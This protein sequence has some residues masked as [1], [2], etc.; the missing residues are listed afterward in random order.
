MD[1][2]VISE[3]GGL[4]VYVILFTT[5]IFNREVSTDHVLT[6]F[7]IR[8]RWL[9]SLTLFLFKTRNK[10]FAWRPLAYIPCE[11]YYS[12]KQYRDFPT[13]TKIFR[14]FQLY[15]AGLASFIKA[16]QPGAMNDVYLPLGDKGKVV[17]MLIPLAFIIG[18]NQGGDGIAGRAAYYGLSA[19]RISR[20]CDATVA[21]YA[22]IQ[23]D[24][25]L[26]LNM[27]EIKALVD[28]QNVLMLDNSDELGFFY[29]GLGRQ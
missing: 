17:N 16:Q 22:T 5:A 20:N 18:D 1:K 23:H 3:M 8:F 14:L 10:S 2:T 12:Q 24:S 27:A 25:C 7:V 29:K 13:D 26:P 28:A 19:R 4:N 15:E 9:W 21:T 11:Q 6:I